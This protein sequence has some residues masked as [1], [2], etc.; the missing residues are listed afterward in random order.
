[1]KIQSN[2]NI[3][4][5]EYIL[6]EEKSYE[7][8]PR[9]YILLSIYKKKIIPLYINAHIIELKFTYAMHYN[10]FDRTILI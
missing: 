8:I 4:S 6:Q 10:N 1:M 3:I 5:K 7:T 2:R 9:L